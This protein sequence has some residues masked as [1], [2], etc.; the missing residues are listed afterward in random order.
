M[1]SSLNRKME[2]LAGSPRATQI[3]SNVTI[4][5]GHN[6]KNEEEHKYCH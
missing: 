6:G 5:H 4:G 3:G 1:L 2:A